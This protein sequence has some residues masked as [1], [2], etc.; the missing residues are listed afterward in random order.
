MYTFEWIIDE[1]CAKCNNNIPCLVSETFFPFGEKQLGLWLAAHAIDV[2]NDVSNSMYCLKIRLHVANSTPRYSKWSL[3][4]VTITE[5][6]ETKAKDIYAGR[7]LQLLVKISDQGER[8]T[9][10]AEL[11]QHH[12]T[13]T[14]SFAS[15]KLLERLHLY[16]TQPL[17]VRCIICN[18]TETLS[19]V[20]HRA[21]DE[22]WYKHRL[23]DHLQQLLVD[24]KSNDCTLIT[25]KQQ[26]ETHVG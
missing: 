23:F 21:A 14:G 13:Y 26:I 20:V 24:D 4:V 1:F 9:S 19:K 16:S 2:G 10:F 25:Q 6:A 8:R 17:I 7:A 15:I 5:L 3:C 22:Q 11:T 12:F 18:V